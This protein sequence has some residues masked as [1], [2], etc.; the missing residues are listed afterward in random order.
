MKPIP[1]IEQNPNGLHGRY[2]IAKA[3][4]S[5]VDSNAEYFVLRV[6]A[7]GDE[8]HVRACRNA[9]A[10]YATGIAPHL[11]QL[12]AELQQRYFLPHGFV[13]GWELMEKQTFQTHEDKGWTDG[14]NTADHNWHGNQLALIHSELSEALEGLRKDLDD[15]KL[16]H[17][18]M[19]EVELAD[20]VIRI[21]NYGRQAG[22]D[23][24]AAIVEKAAFNQTRP[25]KHGD[26]KF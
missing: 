8:D 6:D 10:V 25:H 2:H 24:A 5:P 17:R 20:A 18:K 15:D 19:V 16:P 14:A 4:G 1:S 13:R 23:V 26:K 7:N 12:A 21:M 22:Y 3:D 11:P 9:L